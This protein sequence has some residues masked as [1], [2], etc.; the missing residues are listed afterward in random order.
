MFRG[1]VFTNYVSMGDEGAFSN[2]G[3]DRWFCEQMFQ[4]LWEGVNGA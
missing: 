2:A 1:K 3:E 4:Q